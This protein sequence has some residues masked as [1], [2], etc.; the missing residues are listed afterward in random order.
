MQL[1]HS[2]NNRL[3]GFGVD[4][5][6]KSRIFLDQLDQT[7]GKLFLLG[8]GAGLDSHRNNGLRKLDSFKDNGL[9]LNTKSVTGESLFEA[10]RGDN[11]TCIGS[12]DLLLS[13][14]FLCVIFVMFDMFSRSFSN[15]SK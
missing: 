12:L 5:D 13:I 15:L 2:G 11:I 1:A 9:I 4:F 3:I 7:I 14:S 8:F 10:N 6:C